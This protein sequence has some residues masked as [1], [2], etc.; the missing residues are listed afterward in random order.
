VKYPETEGRVERDRRDQAMIADRTM[1]FFDN[2]DRLVVAV[3][4]LL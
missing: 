4:H 2:V 3:L 1:C